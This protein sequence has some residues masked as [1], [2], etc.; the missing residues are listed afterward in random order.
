MQEL[1]KFADRFCNIFIDVF[2]LSNKNL[3]FRRVVIIM[4]NYNVIIVILVVIFFYKL[5]L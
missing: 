1:A 5:C 3:P 4:I 2:A